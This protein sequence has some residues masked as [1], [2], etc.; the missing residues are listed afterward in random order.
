M[1]LDKFLILE[2]KMD[3]MQTPPEIVDKIINFVQSQISFND[4][5]LEPFLGSGNIYK[6]IPNKKKYFCDTKNG[7]NFFDWNKKVD[8]AISN[9]PFQLLYNGKPIN[10]FILI[11]DRLIE[12]CNKGFF[13]LINHKLWSSLTVKR[14][15]T[16]QNKNWFISQ[17]L[18]LEVKQ[19]YGRYYLIKFELGGKSI[20]NI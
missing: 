19:W 11:I 20:L 14:I 4:S 18:I 1:S 7:I 17:I 12:L 13:L 2:K 16:W 5:I 9:P 8:W 15:K 10:S 6:K 3:L